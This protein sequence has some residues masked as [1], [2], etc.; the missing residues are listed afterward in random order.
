MQIN[1]TV[2]IWIEDS[3]FVAHAM[4]L[5]IMSSGET[6]EKA[7][8]ALDEAVHLFLVTAADMDTLEEILQ[9]TGYKLQD[10]N[11]I[12]PDWV[13]IERHSMTVGV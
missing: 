9:E 13:A 11:W 4:P 1:Y 10:G 6:Q 3:Q 8:I 12:S 7:R 5:D 2:Q